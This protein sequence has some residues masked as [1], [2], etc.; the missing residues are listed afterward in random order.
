MFENRLIEHLNLFTDP[1]S[2]A[3][4]LCWVRPGIEK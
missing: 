3:V 1:I 2:E 4:C